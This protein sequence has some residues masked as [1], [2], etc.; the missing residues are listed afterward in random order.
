M[1][2]VSI[3]CLIVTL[4]VGCLLI[5]FYV[6]NS[7][8]FKFSIKSLLEQEL[9]LQ[10]EIAK[11][12]EEKNHLSSLLEILND[13][14]NDKHYN[15]YEQIREEQKE[16]ENLRQTH[17]AIIEADQREQEIQKQIDFYTIELDSNE[18]ND[19]SILEELKPKL[20]QPRILSMLIWQTYIQ[21][22]LNKI[23]TNILGGDVVTGIYKITN[24]TTKES[25][26]GQSVDIKKRWCEHAK[27]GLGIDT[28]PQNKLYD[29]IKKYGIQYFSWEL[30]EKCSR[31]ELN[32]KERYYINLYDSIN[33]GYNSN[34]GVR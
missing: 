1:I 32:E 31:E 9:F 12:T 21:K 17:R 14:Y 18:I 34:I 3:I 26:I 5:I 23:C 2:T 8:K 33:Y 13:D 16:L 15:L 30:L 11:I 28:P 24:Q 25:Y 10:D 7:S 20:S 4:L 6:L 29:A 22:K 19:I 27:C